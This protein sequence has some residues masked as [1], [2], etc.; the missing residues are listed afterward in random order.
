VDAGWASGQNTRDLYKE[1]EYTKGKWGL[2]SVNQ[3]SNT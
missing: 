2:P 3:D 1:K